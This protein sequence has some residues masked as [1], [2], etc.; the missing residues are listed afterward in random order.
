MAT[1]SWLEG[2]VNSHTLL[3]NTTYV[4]DRYDSRTTTFSP[5]GRLFQVCPAVTV[6]MCVLTFVEG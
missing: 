5:E 4:S 6:V 2:E 1:D 3:E